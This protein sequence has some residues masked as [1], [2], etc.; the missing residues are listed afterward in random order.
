[1]DTIRSNQFLLCGISVPKSVIVQLNAGT[2]AF[3]S[4]QYLL[5]ACTSF[6]VSP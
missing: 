3:E 4:T 1:V 2:N 5:F 6:N